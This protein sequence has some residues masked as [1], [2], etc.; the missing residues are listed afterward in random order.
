MLVV[1]ATTRMSMKGTSHTSRAARAV[2]RRAVG[3]RPLGAEPWLPSRRPAQRGAGGNPGAD[4]Q[5]DPG[6][7][8]AGTQREIGCQDERWGDAEAQP[9]IGDLAAGG[10]EHGGKSK[11]S[12]FPD[13]K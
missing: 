10:G 7:A 3:A 12:R 8:D 6:G 4:D 11:G 13:P 9:E 5:D 1:L 2:S